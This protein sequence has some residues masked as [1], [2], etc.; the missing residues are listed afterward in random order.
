MKILINGMDQIG[1]TLYSRPLVKR[2]VDEHNQVWLKTSLPNLYTYSDNSHEKIK[3]LNPSEIKLRTP[4]TEN[5]LLKSLYTDQTSPVFDR[6]IEPLYS[7]TDLKSQGHF[8]SM[9]KRFG[10]EPGSSMDLQFSLPL[11]INPRIKIPPGKKLAIIRPV[12]QR[13]EFQCLTRPPEAAYI[14]WICRTL[15]A[16]GYYTISMADLEPGKEWLEIEPPQADLVLHKGELGILGTISLM[17][18]ADLIVG[19]PGFII[20]AAILGKV[21]LFIVFGGRGEYENPQKLFDLR[22]DLRQVGWALPDVFCRCSK[23]VHD[24]T[25]KISDLDSQFFQFMKTLRNH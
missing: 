23:N 12:T 17:A 1:D 25:K 13:S 19:G 15:R 5:L 14:N 11:L 20:P 21:P 16:Q 4:L 3:F 24:C 10:W 9:E 18:S 22:M 2:L 8:G 6:V 7:G